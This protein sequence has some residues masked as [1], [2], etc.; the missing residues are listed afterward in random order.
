MLIESLNIIQ[1]SELRM[2]R[3]LLLILVSVELLLTTG[4]HLK[5]DSPKRGAIT[6]NQILCRPNFTEMLLSVVQSRHQCKIWVL[7]SEKKTW[8]SLWY[9][10]APHLLQYTKPIEEPKPTASGEKIKKKKMTDMEILEK[11]RTI[12]S[13][14]DP[15]RKYTDLQKIG[16]GFVYFSYNYVL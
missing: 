15:N 13:V 6:S 12:V 8:G 3:I 9:Q 5:S 7:C 2:E 10:V 11:L 16:Q 14:G 1:T 4:I